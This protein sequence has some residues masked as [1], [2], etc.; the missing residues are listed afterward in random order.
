M[1]KI[2]GLNG[3]QGVIIPHQNVK[4]L[5]LNDEVIEAVKAGDFH[6][7]PVKTIDE[8][9]E[10]LTGIK[11]GEKGEDGKYTE[12]TI[13]YRVYEKLKHFAHTVASFGK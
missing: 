8:G 5:V 13:N 6:I 4:N 7:Y 3:K 1:C 10:I 9:I 2:R 11:C 12:G